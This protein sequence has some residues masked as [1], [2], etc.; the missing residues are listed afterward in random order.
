[1]TARAPTVTLVAL[2]LGLARCREAPRPPP[3]PAPETF[4]ATGGIAPGQTPAVPPD[5]GRAP[6]ALDA[7]AERA[8]ERQLRALA[9]TTTAGFAPRGQP[10]LGTLGPGGARS[11]ALT[12]Q[13]GRCYRALGVASTAAGDLDLAL[14]DAAGAEVESDHTYG[15]WSVLGMRRPWCTDGAALFRVE[16]ALPYGGGAFAMQVFHAPA[17]PAGSAPA[18]VRVR[19]I[20]RPV[21]PIY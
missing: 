19:R 12:T 6:A 20:Y 9:S 10:T 4:A 2:A 3:P 14:Y 11:F 17:P 18:R 8:L 5:A 16:V 13:P 7:E 21:A 1:M 15:Q